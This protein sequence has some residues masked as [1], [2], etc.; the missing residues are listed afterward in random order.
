MKFKSDIE[1][2]AGIKDSSGFSGTSGQVLSST[3]TGVSWVSQTGFVTLDT[4]QTITG[5]KTFTNTTAGVGIY[6]GNSSSGDGIFI[7]NS[8][9]GR[10]I[11]LTNTST[12]YG[13]FASNT[14]TGI[15][16]FLNNTSTGVSALFNNTSSGKNLILNNST[17]GTG[18]PF[19]VQKNNIDVATISDSGAATVSSLILS[20]GT[21]STGLYYG[22]TNKVVLANYTVGGGIDFETNG[23]AINMVLDAPGNLSV[24]GTVTAASIIKSGGTSSQF[25]KADGSV[26]NTTYQP[27]IAHL[28]FN[29]TNKTIWNNGFS[30]G[31]DNTSFG[32]LALSTNTT[33]YENTAYGYNSL[34]ANLT[35][36]YNAANGVDSLKNNTSGSNNTASGSDALR[37]NETGNYNTAV[38]ES[39]LIYNINGSSNVSIGTSSGSL[40]YDGLTILSIDDSVFIG[41]GSRGLSQSGDTNQIVIGS[42]AIG[43]GSN[44]VVLGNDSI[45]KTILKGNVG[46]GTTSPS[47]KLQ[48]NISESGSNPGAVLRLENTGA[49]YTSKLILTDG[50]TNDANISYLGATQSLGFGIGSSLN[51]MVLTSGGNVGIG[52]TS[53]SV[54][55]HSYGGALSVG[56]ESSYSARFSNNSNKG[57][58]IGY[59]STNNKGH[60][61]SI[62]P[63]VAWT[64]LILNAN[65]G[66]VGIGTTSPSEKLSIASTDEYLLSWIRTG[67]SKRWA[68]GADSGG[69]FIA[70]RTDSVLSFYVKNNGNVGIGT[71]SPAYALDVLTNA[72]ISNEGGAQKY[73]YFRQTSLLQP[74]AA[75]VGAVDDGN[76]SH[77]LQ[78]FT[79]VPGANNSALTERMRITSSG[80][81]LIGATSTVSSDNG[82]KLFGQSGS[83]LGS[84]SQ[85]KD[86]SS[87]T[88]TYNYFEIS[89]GSVVGTI[90]YNGSSVSYNTSS[91]YRLKEDFKDYSG[92]DLISKIKTYDYKWKSNKSRSYGVLAHELQEVLPYAV[93]GEKDNE[94]MQQV[95]YSKLVP[96][97][98]Q[99]IKEL[100]AE[101]EIL[102]TK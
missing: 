67:D 96:I 38:G 99:A 65:G 95:D 31:S 35:G 97:L 77:H 11:A 75:A 10:G 70:N 52:T 30:N 24:V 101:I 87:G 102:K 13:I 88:I 62:N 41:S 20:G 51:Q 36:N 17:A 86:Y 61:G 8:S 98:V 46:I 47:A 19:S 33:G 68:F 22:H 83:L 74:N 69:T 3:A 12:G 59:D 4:D 60:I 39:A 63:A 79:K 45:A 1:V 48:V 18:M 43:A 78:F 91:D 23:G 94:Q 21:G 54:K 84:I 64:D 40:T 15:G 93:T 82:I 32:E 81:V 90:T 5:K 28:E 76:Y 49:N 66:N 55:F 7:A 58:V 9:T 27:L 14:S 57:V 80:D 92:L 29:N 44:S 50:T 53:P 56:D 37:N 100:K 16:T 42:N 34:N 26:D 72:A 2:E 85:S 25:L 89:S 71:T 6:S 73:L